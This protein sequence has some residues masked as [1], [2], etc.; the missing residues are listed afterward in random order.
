MSDNTISD[1]KSTILKDIAILYK[2]SESVA[3]LDMVLSFAH[4][5]TIHAL[6]KAK[7]V[8][9]KEAIHAKND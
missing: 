2:F 4:L 8:S 9:Q 6:G 7:T 5:C 1:L 3:L